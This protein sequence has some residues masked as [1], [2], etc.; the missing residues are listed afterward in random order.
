MAEGTDTGGL[1]SVR[2]HLMCTLTKNSWQRHIVIAMVT[3]N[4]TIAVMGRAIFKLL[5]IAIHILL[6]TLTVYI[7]YLKKQVQFYFVPDSGSEME[8][9]NALANPLFTCYWIC[10]TLPGQQVMRFL[11]THLNYSGICDNAPYV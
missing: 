1:G 10:P 8:A 9:V 11:H 7:T 5:P 3:L 6:N 4:A 2:F